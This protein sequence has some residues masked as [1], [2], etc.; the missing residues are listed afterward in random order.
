M[1]E[2]VNLSSGWSCNDTKLQSASLPFR[3]GRHQGTV[4]S[5]KFRPSA[6][7]LSIP[8]CSV[9][10]ASLSFSPHHRY[11]AYFITAISPLSSFLVGA[12]AADIDFWFP[13]LPSIHFF[14]GGEG[15]LLWSGKRVYTPQSLNGPMQSGYEHTPAS[16]NQLA[17]AYCDHDLPRLVEGFAESLNWFTQFSLKFIMFLTQT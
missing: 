7:P 1:K 11:H 2:N 13:P 14:G 9:L 17:A 3:F 6:A 4:T 8:L 5:I 16:H 12:A 10:S 15:G